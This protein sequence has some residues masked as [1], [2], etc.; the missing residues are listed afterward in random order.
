MTAHRRDERYG[1][2]AENELHGKIVS[3]F[4]DVRR[5]GKWDIFDYVGDDIQI[6]LKNRRILYNQYPTIM[7]GLNKLKVA[8]KSEKETWFCWNFTNGLYKWKFNKDEYE[9]E[10]GGRCDRGYDERKAC[11]FIKM[12]FLKPI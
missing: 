12:S 3:V 2:K 11:G 8:E 6:E 1:E 7:I 4:G 5:T 9:I 10:E